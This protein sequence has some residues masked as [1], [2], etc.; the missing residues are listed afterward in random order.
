[1]GKNSKFFFKFHEGLRLRWRDQIFQMTLCNQFKFFVFGNIKKVFRKF[2]FIQANIFILKIKKDFNK[3]R[4]FMSQILTSN[5]RPTCPF[6]S[7]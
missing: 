1:M 4:Y 5:A 6:V 7:T 2:A 3:N